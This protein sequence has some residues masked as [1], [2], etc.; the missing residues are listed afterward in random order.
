[1]YRTE[2]INSMLSLISGNIDR[3]EQELKE[4]YKKLIQISADFD[5]IATQFV[6]LQRK[7]ISEREKEYEATSIANKLWAQINTT[8]GSDHDAKLI[9]E[10]AMSVMDETSSSAVM[11][12]N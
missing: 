11:S 7:P 4:E 1:M 9:S 6:L 12:R 5:E 8:F 10:A 2:K 3:L